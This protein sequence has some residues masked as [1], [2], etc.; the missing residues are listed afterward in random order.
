MCKLVHEFLPL[1]RVELPW[2]CYRYTTATDAGLIFLDSIDFYINFVFLLTGFF[3]TLGAGWIYDIEN[4]V[5]T[6]G[7]PL[8]VT[9]MVSHFGSIIVACSVWFGANNEN[10]VWGGF[11]AL[12][13]CGFAGFAVTG[14][15]LN[16]KMNAEPGKW[17]W[18]SIIYELALGNVMRLRAELQSVVG[19]LPWLWAF[20][21]KNLIPQILLILFINLAQSN[22]A[23]GESLFGHYEGYVS[24]PFQVLGILVVCFASLFVLAGFVAPSIFEGA[25]IPARN[26]KQAALAKDSAIDPSYPGEAEDVEK[27]ALPIEATETVGKQE[28]S[29]SEGEIQA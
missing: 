28:G 16:Q 23:D 13:L 21:M 22:N 11:V 25:D 10:E 12:F 24:W 1:T 18:G 2:F 19:Y 17:T 15:L 26:A 9:Y 8:V 7:A 5:A 27:T 3:E 14:V 29:E 4:Q 20:A 6:L